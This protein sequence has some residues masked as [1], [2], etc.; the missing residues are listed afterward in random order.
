MVAIKENSFFQ[1]RLRRYAEAEPLLIGSH[2]ALNF[3]LGQRDPRTV[4]AL[5]LVSLYEAWNNL[6]RAAHYRALL[7]GSAM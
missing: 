7:V 2:A 6:D 5:R 4:E 1:G 3:R